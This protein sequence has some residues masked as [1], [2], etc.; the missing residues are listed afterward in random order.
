[1][2]MYLLDVIFLNILI[3][4]NIQIHGSPLIYFICFT[5]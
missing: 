4:V 5:Y 1:M 2:L 3:E